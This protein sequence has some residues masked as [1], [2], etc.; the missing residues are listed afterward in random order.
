MTFEQKIFGA[1]TAQSSLT[2]ALCSRVYAVTSGRDTPVPRIVYTNTD[3]G[4]DTTFC[5]PSGLVAHGVDVDVYAKD[6]D[7]LRPIETAIKA[8]LRGVFGTNAVIVESVSDAMAPEPGNYVRTITL[9]LWSN[10][11]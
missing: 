10:E 1:I 11:Q 7:E 4:E 8:D 2:K 5:G 6:F 3:A 9:T